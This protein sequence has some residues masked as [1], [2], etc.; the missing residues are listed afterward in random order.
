MPERAQP[1]AALAL[2]SKDPAERERDHG[3]DGEVHVHAEVGRVVLSL[4]QVVEEGHDVQL[5]AAHHLGPL[6]RVA[7]SQQVPRLVDVRAQTATKN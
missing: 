1:P 6:V 7:H 2:L 3:L 4:G 5:A